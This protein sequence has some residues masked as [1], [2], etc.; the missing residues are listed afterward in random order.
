MTTRTPAIRTPATRVPAVLALAARALAG[1]VLVTVLTGSCAWASSSAPRVAMVVKAL[2]NPFFLELV[3]GA[4][5]A[6]TARGV[7]LEVFGLEQETEVARQIAIVENVAARDFKVL[8]IAPADSVRLLPPCRKAQRAGLVVVNVDNA[9]DAATMARSG[10][11]IPF[12]GPDN[13]HGAALVGE[14]VGR[15]LGGQGKVMLLE[16]SRDALNARQRKEGF[17]NG[18]RAAGIEDVLASQSGNWIAEEAFNALAGM[19][20]QHGPPDAVLCANDAMALG[21]VQALDLFALAGKTI[22]AGYDNIDAVRHEIKAGRIMATVDQHPAAMGRLAVELAL[23]QLAGKPAAE[24]VTTPTDLVTA[25]DL[26]GQ[27]AETP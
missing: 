19:I 20:E 25:E 17:L 4:R 6:A 22:V 13:Y 3:R 26:R 16:G 1:L 12:V 27:E 5:E 8:I 9:F 21:A 14:Y 7:E 11:P 18:L 15:R 10:P 23:D 2:G 24:R